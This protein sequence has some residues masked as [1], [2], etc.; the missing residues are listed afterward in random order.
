MK[1]LIANLYTVQDRPAPR[2]TGLEAPGRIHVTREELQQLFAA[3]LAAFGEA[4][5]S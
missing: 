1:K 3:E 2:L 4:D 5:A